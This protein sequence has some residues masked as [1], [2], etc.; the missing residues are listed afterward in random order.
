MGAPSGRTSAATPRRGI[1]PTI[2]ALA[3][4]AVARAAEGAGCPPAPILRAAGLAP[5]TPWRIEAR[6]TLRQH[7]AA[8]ETALRLVRDPG[9]PIDVARG[10]R[11]EDYELYGFVMMAS[12]TL[13]EAFERASRFRQAWLEAGRWEVAAAGALLR[14]SWHPGRSARR[15]TLGQRGS[16]E[17]NVAELLHVARLLSGRPLVPLEVSFRHAAPPDASAHARHFGVAPR[18]GAPLDGLVL[19]AEVL[20][21]PTAAGN[22]RLLAHFERE[23]AALAARFGGAASPVARVRQLLAEAM[24]GSSPTVEAVARRM[25]AS[26]RTLHR[27]LAEEGTHYQGLLDEVRA[28]FARRYLGQAALGPSEV[29]YL[30]GFASPS[31]FFRAFRRWTGTTPRAFAEGARPGRGRPAAPGA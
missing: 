5:G 2:S 7:E 25:G 16:V 12:A 27:R 31:A 28:D 30:L 11:V 13:G 29:S 1:E 20:G 24:S 9:F 23:C 15:R 19:P 18:F 8:W 4:L 17:C 14:L 26:P 21:W 10:A 22:G 3:T 6:T